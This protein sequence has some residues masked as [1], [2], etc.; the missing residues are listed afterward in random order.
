MLWNSE[1]EKE[2]NETFV[3]T[4]KL[5]RKWIDVNI[6]CSAACPALTDIPGYIQAI[7]AGDF[8]NGSSTVIEAAEDGYK[9][10]SEYHMQL[11]GIKAFIL[12]MT[13][14]SA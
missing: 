9:V 5:D 7:A 13:C 3:S 4:D 11:S 1:M 2:K 8:R 12:S 10:A 14:H 6:P